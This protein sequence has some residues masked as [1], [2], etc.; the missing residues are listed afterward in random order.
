[1][2]GSDDPK[3]QGTAFKGLPENYSMVRQINLQSHTRL[4]IIL[5]LLSLVILVIA[6]MA[7]FSILNVLRPGSLRLPTQISLGINDGLRLVLW[8]SGLSLLMIVV[9]EGIHGF[10]FRIITHENVKYAFRGVYAFAAA[11]GW[12]FLR[13]HYLSICLAPLIIINLFCSAA[14][15]FAPR[16]WLVPFFYLLIMNI[17]AASSDMLIAAI[18]FKYPPNT[19]YQDEGDVFSIYQPTMQSSS[20]K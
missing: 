9:H 8:A 11:P 14:L 20:T 12:Y 3:T 15:C 13:R 2:K 5:N 4:G 1:M 10:F 7:A 19:L 17:A 18:L 6:G 16:S